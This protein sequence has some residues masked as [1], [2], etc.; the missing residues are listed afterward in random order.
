ML[1]LTTLQY[2][3]LRWLGSSHRSHLS[4]AAFANKSKL[5]VLLG[6]EFC[7]NLKGKV[8]VDFGCG[9]GLEAIDMVAH[10]AVGVIGV[11]IR[12]TIL[13]QARQHASDALITHRCEFTTTPSLSDADAIVSIDAFEHFADPSEVLDVMYRLLVPGGFVVASFGPTWFH[14]YGGHLFSIFP[15]AHLLFSEEA[16]IR[17]RSDFKTD[18][19]RSFGEVEGGLNQMTIRRFEAL[20]GKSQFQVDQLECV[21]I[22][23]L[24]R[25]HSR[26]TR[27][28]TTAVVRCRLLKVGT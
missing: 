13:A 25:F 1:M 6:D 5:R 17:W 19:A 11:D 22:R 9:E 15:W 20:I 18:G 14:P 28:F 26:F 23:P 7:R 21:P 2:R 4:G 8:I 10:G 16:L 24:R 12:E 3:I 27:E